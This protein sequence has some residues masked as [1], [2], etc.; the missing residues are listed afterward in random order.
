M[1]DPRARL[2]ELC[3]TQRVDYATLSRLVGRNPAYIQQYLRRGTPRDLAERDRA[4]IAAFFDVDESELGAPPRHAGGTGTL[5]RVPRLPIRAAA[6]AGSL[7]EERAG[8]AHFGFDRGWLRDLTAARPE[9]LAVIKVEGDSMAPTL[10]AGDEILIDRSDG[11]ERLRDGI[12]V[13][14]K[15]DALMVKRLALHP[16]GRSVTIQSDNPA[17]IDFPGCA[18]EE[19][20]LVGRVLWT[21]RR[22][23]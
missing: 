3:R 14:R 21:A 12:Y 10:A 16:M 23:G 13:L 8:G 15:E 7:N 2:E 6:G 9:D 5:V 19:I 17:Y 11:A 1:N 4:A 20:D 22:L 18:L